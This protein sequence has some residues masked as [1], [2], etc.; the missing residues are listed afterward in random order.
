[1]SH[2]GLD[3]LHPIMEAS[4]YVHLVVGTVDVLSHIIRRWWKCLI[5]LLLLTEHDVSK[6]ISS[7][8]SLL[9]GW[10]DVT[11]KCVTFSE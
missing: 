9:G 10:I 4:P 6:L 7:L 3:L 11:Y 2:W 5:L 1:M 8:Q